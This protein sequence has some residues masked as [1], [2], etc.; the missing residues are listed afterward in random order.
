MSYLDQ[1]TALGDDPR[2][3]EQLYR[4]ADAAGDRDAFSAAIE[5]RHRAAPDHLLYAAWYHRLHASAGDAKRTLIAWGWLIPLALL[6]AL[7]F[8]GLSAERFAIWLLPNHPDWSGQFAPA[9]ALLVA[10][11]SALIVFAY[12]TA[13]LR[14]GGRERL[15]ISLCLLLAVGYVLWSYRLIGTRPFQEQYLAL[16][17]LHLPLLTWAA[18]GLAALR[19]HGEP[20]DRLSFLHKSLELIIT[21]GLFLIAGVLFVAVT[22]ALFAALDVEIPSL[23]QRL[24]IAGGG[25]LIP[26]LAMPL[27][28]DPTTP[29]AAQ[30]F[31]DG[32]GKLLTTLMRL[33][34]PLTLLL[35]LVYVAFIPF[36]FSE[37]FKN[38]EVLVT[39]NAMLF[40]VVALL[41]GATPRHSGELSPRLHRWLRG[42]ICAV[43]ALALL[44]SLYALA[45]ILYRTADD[46]LTPNRIAFIG[47]NLI[48]IALLA[49][50]LVQQWRSKG[51]WLAALQRTF[52]RGMVAYA[53]WTVAIILL[54]PWGFRLDQGNITALPPSIQRLVVT[55]P[56]PL[57]LKCRGRDPIYLLDDGRKR[58]IE[59]IATFEAQGYEW[60]DVSLVA[61]AELR[62]IPSGIPIPADAGP[63]PEP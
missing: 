15:L 21:M 16:M 38:R 1:L 47:W 33:L 61:C 8:W 2:E 18:L 27:V 53:L 43:A 17:L 10:P 58:W 23:W 59:D 30:S 14:R 12:V 19:H 35:L 4:R 32:V 39:F 9:L 45:A 44:V 56:A 11:L 54:L 28:Y 52:G 13:V 46:R 50:L 5:E 48:N 20:P 3:L 40:A 6:N 25:G 42:A 51:E 55:Q 24:L 37:P 62:A 7:L 29:P 57:L 63:I 34:L 60:R 22:F 41:V 26:V 49:L 31:D 36:N